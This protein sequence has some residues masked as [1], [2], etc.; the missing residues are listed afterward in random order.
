MDPTLHGNENAGS[1]GESQVDEARMARRRLLKL[2]AATA[3]L[4]LTFKPSSAW[5]VS[6]GCI[7]HHGQRETPGDLYKVDNNMQR[8]VRDD[9]GIYYR[10]TRG[11]WKYWY[12]GGKGWQR[13]YYELTKGPYRNRRHYQE[14]YV[15][16]GPG[17]VVHSGNVSHQKLRSLVYNDNVGWSCVSSIVNS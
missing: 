11:R 6:A 9:N 7:L 8:M 1:E 2:G 10:F 16:E 15:N 14:I 5:A 4:V 12:Q 17:N 13:G 3:P